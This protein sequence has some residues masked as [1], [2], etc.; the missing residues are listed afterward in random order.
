MLTIDRCDRFCCCCG[1]CGRCWLSLSLLWW[2]LKKNLKLFEPTLNKSRD[3]L[4]LHLQVC[5]GKPAH[6]ST[7]TTTATTTTSNDN[8]DHN[9]NKSDHSCHLTTSTTTTVTTTHTNHFNQTPGHFNGSI[10]QHR[11]SSSDSRRDT[12]RATGMFFY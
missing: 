12:S 8:N 1:R 11:S 2:W 6:C 10:R 9:N 4:I 3:L 7:T 5:H